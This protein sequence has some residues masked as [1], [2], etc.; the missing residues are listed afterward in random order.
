MIDSVVLDFRGSTYTE[1]RLIHRDLRYLLYLFIH[2]FFSSRLSE[3][4]V[5][6]LKSEDSDIAEPLQINVSTIFCCCYDSYL[7]SFLFFIFP[8]SSVMHV[9]DI[10]NVRVA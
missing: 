1:N 2:L 7:S 3:P 6:S 5:L 4:A 10:S 8:F 9:P